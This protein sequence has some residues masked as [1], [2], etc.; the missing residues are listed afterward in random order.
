MVKTASTAYD[1]FYV[2]SKIPFGEY[3]LRVSAKQQADLGQ[4]AKTIDSLSI[5][6]E[7]Q[8]LSGLDFILREARP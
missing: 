2:M 1:G 6:N 8:F 7:S 4:E 5:N 3:S